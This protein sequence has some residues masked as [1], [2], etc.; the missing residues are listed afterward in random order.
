VKGKNRG[1]HCAVPRYISISI[2]LSRVDHVAQ[3]PPRPRDAEWEKSMGICPNIYID[4]QWYSMSR[5]VLSSELHAASSRVLA[6]IGTAL[7][8]SFIKLWVL[9]PGQSSMRCH[10][11]IQYCI[12]HGES[13]S[14]FHDMTIKQPTMQGGREQ[15]MEIIFPAAGR[16][17]RRVQLPLPLWHG[18]TL[19]SDSHL[20]RCARRIRFRSLAPRRS[21]G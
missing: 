8:P 10:D 2:S 1:R 19:Q 21:P 12:L 15:S 16:A 17:A 11:A 13:P 18:G 14:Q 4:I 6:W 3:E 20:L 9:S 5:D 7:R